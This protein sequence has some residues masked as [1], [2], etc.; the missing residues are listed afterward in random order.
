MLTMRTMRSAV[1]AA[2]IGLGVSGCLW[3][4]APGR[5][6]VV[7]RRPPPARF[8]VYGPAPGPGYVWISGYWGW[9]G[10]DFVWIGG[11]WD[12]PPHGYRHWEPSHWE[13]HNGGWRLHK[14]HWHR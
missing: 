2:L 13:R 10:G 14:G 9:V 8:E 7:D 5:V 11:R 4:P 1:L 6:V 3:V 12:L